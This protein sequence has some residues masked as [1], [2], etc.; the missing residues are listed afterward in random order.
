MECQLKELLCG[1]KAA[2]SGDG[3]VQLLD[4]LALIVQFPIF[5]FFW[6]GC[7]PTQR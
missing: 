2:A 7:N 4:T 3:H 5:F 1:L 6:R